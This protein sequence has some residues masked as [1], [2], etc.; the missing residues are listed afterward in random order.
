MTKLFINNASLQRIRGTDT[1]LLLNNLFVKLESGEEIR[2]P[3]GF[4]TDKASVPLGWIVKR[5][6]KYIIDGA[7]V[8]DYLY[9]AQKIRR[10]FI[11]RHHADKILIEICKHSGMGWF[12]RKAVWLGVRAGGWKYWNKRADVLGNTK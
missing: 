5:D 3:K 12:K 9:S 10:T 7:L 6:D 2:V 4:I 11:S 1:W 8:H